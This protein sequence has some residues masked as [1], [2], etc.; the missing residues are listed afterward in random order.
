VFFPILNPG[1]SVTFAPISVLSPT[2]PTTFSL[3]FSNTGV[4]VKTNPYL[5]VTFSPIIAFAEIVHLLPKVV[6]FPV[7][8]DSLI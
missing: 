4:S 2:I 7:F 5:I 3:F 8:T 6:L 1:I